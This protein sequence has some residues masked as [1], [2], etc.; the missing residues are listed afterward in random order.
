MEDWRCW[1]LQ[2]FCTSIVVGPTHE[3]NR[4]IQWVIRG[5]EG[6]R[7]AQLN[8]PSWDKGHAGG[9]ILARARPHAFVLRTDV[10]LFLQDYN[11]SGLFLRSRK[12]DRFIVAVSYLHSYGYRDVLKHALWVLFQLFYKLI[13]FAC[14][15]RMRRKQITGRFLENWT[16]T[17]DNLNNLHVIIFHRIS[18]LEKYCMIEFLFF[19]L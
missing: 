3:L 6:A 19:A 11:L 4:W 18:S 5:Y 13:S 14:G 8:I 10:P 16:L 17:I 7:I 2:D 9:N 1:T 15:M 12:K